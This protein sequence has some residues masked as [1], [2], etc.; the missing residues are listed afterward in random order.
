MAN[1]VKIDWTNRDFGKNLAKFDEVQDMLESHA[2][3]LASA[4]S[5]DLATH[6]DTGA[7]Q[8]KY[9]GHQSTTEYGHIDHYVIM[10]GPAPISVE[11]GH[12]TTNGKWVSG[13]YILTRA[14]FS[15]RSPW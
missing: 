6:R 10:D 4:A 5:A 2:K 7:H 13:L 1:T 14:R 8:V 15:V 11:F 3:K 12:R 9:V